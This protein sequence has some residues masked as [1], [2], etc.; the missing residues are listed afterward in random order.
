MLSKNI[1]TIRKQK[2]LTIKD[3]AKIVGVS[4]QAIS[5]YERGIREPNLSTIDKIAEALEV[6]R[7]DLLETT[8]KV[9]NTRVSITEEHIND[10]IKSQEMRTIKNLLD[11]MNINEELSENESKILLKQIKLFIEFEI[12]K[13]KK[14]R[15]ENN[16]GKETK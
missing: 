7:L 8:Y 15:E 1:R 14:E 2:G 16:Y 4:E 10:S 6:T 11:D 9:N 13:L 5:Q 3:V 12:Y